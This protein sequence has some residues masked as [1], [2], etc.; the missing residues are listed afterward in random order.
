MSKNTE[1]LRELVDQYNKVDKSFK[2]LEKKKKALRNDVMEEMDR[3]GVA[4]CDG[5]KLVEFERESL[6]KD[7]LRDVLLKRGVEFSVVEAAF[8]EATQINE[9]RQLR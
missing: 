8:S 9:Q 2:L 4:E 6:N 1:R 7:T 5:R 3:L